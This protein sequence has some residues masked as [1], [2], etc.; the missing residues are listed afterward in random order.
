M[1]LLKSAT[2]LCMAYTADIRRTW[3]KM[4]EFLKNCDVNILEMKDQRGMGIEHR[5]TKAWPHAFDSSYKMN[6]IFKHALSEEM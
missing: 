5:L 3:N 6:D 1:T 2:K 4:C